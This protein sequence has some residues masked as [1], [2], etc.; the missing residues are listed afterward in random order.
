M[1]RHGKIYENQEHTNLHRSSN[2]K[3]SYIGDSAAASLMKD[4]KTKFFQVFLLMVNR[5]GF[6]EYIYDETLDIFYKNHSDNTTVRKTIKKHSV[7][8]KFGWLLFY[9]KKY[10]FNF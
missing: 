5:N 10:K 3:Y 4:R 1:K 6:D 2:I 7:E 9:F 8:G